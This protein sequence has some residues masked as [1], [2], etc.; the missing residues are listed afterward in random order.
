MGIEHVL[1]AR[2]K[3]LTKT[4]LAVLDGNTASLSAV[5]AN[6]AVTAIDGT[7]GK[8]ACA[9]NGLTVVTGGTGI[10]DLTLAEPTPGA[11]AVIR[12]GSLTSGSVVVTCAAKFNGMNNT[13]TFDA[14]NECLM[15]KANGSTWEITA[16]IGGVA[17]STV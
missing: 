8:K 9:V 10:A 12:I 2:L 6:L 7:T 15:L 11:E 16:N 4:E 1:A 5:V 3:G 13:A 14:A 17:L